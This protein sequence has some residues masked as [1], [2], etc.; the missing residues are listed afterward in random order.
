MS[1][2][3]DGVFP[4]FLCNKRKFIQLADLNLRDVD[5]MNVK[6]RKDYEPVR[7]RE[8]LVM[9]VPVM[10]KPTRNGQLRLNSLL[11]KTGHG[12]NFLILLLSVCDDS[13]LLVEGGWM[14]TLLVCMN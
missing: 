2:G 13:P 3:K 11:K 6:N 12:S 5:R 9:M 1:L 7:L 4:V 10:A 14:E 8:N